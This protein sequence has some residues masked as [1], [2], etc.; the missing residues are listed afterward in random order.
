VK[1]RVLVAGFTTR[2]VAQ[3]AFRAGYL[4]CAVDHFC[5]QDLSWYTEDRIRFDELGDLPSA[6]DEMRRRH[7][8]DMMIL[9][10][11]AED[12]ESATAVC[13]TTREVAGRFM[14]K[15]ETQAFFERLRV[16]VPRLTMPGEFPVM[17]KPRRGAG[18]WRNIIAENEK[19]IAAWESENPGLDFIMQTIAAGIPASVCCI[20]DGMRARAVAVNEQILRGTKEYAFGFSGS[21]TPFEHP[22]KSRMIAYAEKIA[23][24]S[25]CTGTIGI[26]FIAGEDA[27]AIEINPRFQATV[28]TVEMATDCNLF[29]MHVDACR[30]SLPATPPHP[31]TFA[32]RSILFAKK[33]M[34]I[35]ADLRHL[36]PVVADIPWPD[37]A[38]EKDQ[39][40]I[41]V[42]GSGA[43]R[44]E[45]L[46]VLD[47]NIRTV[48]QYLQ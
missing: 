5:D 10:S 43:T 36:S 8:F 21:V 42:Y 27:W 39:A 20:T 37:T 13:G 29:R 23:A 48:Q 26:D 11:G 12:L 1:G 35:R 19:D 17:L 4:V 40:I 30:G 44:T 32:A 25:G 3:S 15:L 46:F 6:V 41:S 24:E 16:P 2:H 14:D 22:Q 47:K 45:A 18:G 28:D 7:R 33:D 9:T 34:T 31:K 38:L